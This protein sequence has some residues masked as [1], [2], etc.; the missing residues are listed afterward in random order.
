MSWLLEQI[1]LNFDII[2]VLI[3]FPFMY[4]SE[5]VKQNR[6]DLEDKVRAH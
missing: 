6:T 1:S 2:D 3:L 5:W 4:L